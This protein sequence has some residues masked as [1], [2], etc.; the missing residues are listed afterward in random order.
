MGN[1]FTDKLSLSCLYIILEVNIMKP[2]LIYSKYLESKA[3]LQYQELRQC[4][5][6]FSV[7]F[8]NNSIEMNDFLFVLGITIGDRL[9]FFHI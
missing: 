2:P 3:P 5:Y 8:S 6:L 1:N 7:L 4:V 9:L